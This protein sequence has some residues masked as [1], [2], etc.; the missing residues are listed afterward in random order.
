MQTIDQ[1]AKRASDLI[2]Q[3]LDFSRQS[4]MERQPLDLLSFLKNLFKL[5]KRTLPEN[6]HL[7]LVHAE[8]AYIIFADSSR[9]Q[10]VFMNLAVNARDAMPEGGHLTITLHTLPVT[11]PSDAP[12]P[13]MSPGKW[14][15][16]TVTDSGAG[17]HSEMLSRIFEPFFTT[18]E[19]GQ[20]TGLGLAQ[21]YGIVRQHQGSI[22]VQSEAGQGTS[23]LL[24]FPAYMAEWHEVP[25]IKPDTLPKG[26]GQMVL[27]VEDETATRQALAESLTILN[28]TVKEARNGREALTLLQQH[29]SEIDLIISD[30]VMPEMGGIALLHSL[31]ELKLD[32]PFVIL[33]GHV[34]K[35][36]MEAL[37]TQ[38]LSGWLV[39]PPDL[40]ELAGLLAQLLAK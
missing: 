13:G 15:Q 10:Q 14:I 12:L 7:K 40:A 11:S 36:D 9:L 38:G 19:V 39:K 8:D 30:A 6:I 28:Y 24:Y 5:L 29:R 33:T 32:I 34:I 3:I 18:K 31:R 4:I 20:G 1:Q 37:R 35:K 21:V 25:E 23:F 22:D 16:V 26:E 17:I 2:E 27:L